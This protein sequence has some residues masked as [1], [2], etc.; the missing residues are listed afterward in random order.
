M[1]NGSSEEAVPC[2]EVHMLVKNCNT[3]DYE[4]RILEEVYYMPMARSNLIALSY[5]LM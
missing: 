1:L 5:M 3:G 4:E 2:G